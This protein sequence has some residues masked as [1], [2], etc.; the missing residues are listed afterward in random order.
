MG[1]SLTIPVIEADIVE[2]IE[3]LENNGFQIIVTDLEAQQ[4]YFD[5]DYTGRVAVIAGNEIHGVSDAWRAQ[6]CQKVIIPMLGI[7]DS[8]NVGAATTLVVYE[9]SMRQKGMIRRA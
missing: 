3:W 7:A 4:C 9:A 5:I 8:L 6:K 1:A 2:L